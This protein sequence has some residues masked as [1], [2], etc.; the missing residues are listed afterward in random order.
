[1]LVIRGFDRTTQTYRYA[2]NP[3][4]GSVSDLSPFRVDQFQVQLGLRYRF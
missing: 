4:F 1:L 2:V 3:S